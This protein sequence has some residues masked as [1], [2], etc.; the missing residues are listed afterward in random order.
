MAVQ[1]KGSEFER[2]IC[3]RLSLWWTDDER[4]D[5][6]WRSSQSGGRATLRSRKG[7]RTAG[8][9]GD[10]T[11]LDPI[12]EPLMKMFTIELKR[13]SSYSSPGDLIDFKKGNSAHPWVKCFLQAKRCHEECGSHTWL[14][15]C[16]RDHRE[17]MAFADAF[18]MSQLCKHTSHTFTRPPFFAFRF[19]VHD[20]KNFIDMVNIVGVP[21]ELFLYRIKP[22]EIIN[23][24]RYD[25]KTQS[26]GPVQS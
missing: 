11:A 20:G 13:G 22:Q 18:M 24:L 25:R 17:P 14:L 21:L 5:V 15:I 10:I 19:P 26:T 7:I 16:K 9:Y 6:F 23:Y 1:S 2:Q 8:S 3:K 4:D 12:G